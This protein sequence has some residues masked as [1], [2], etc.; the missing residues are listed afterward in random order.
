MANA[1][2]ARED[3]SLTLQEAKV[4]YKPR[5]AD[6]RPLDNRRI[7]TQLKRELR[8]RIELALGANWNQISKNY[9]AHYLIWGNPQ[10][11]TAEIF[12]KDSTVCYGFGAVMR[13]SIR[14]A[15]PQREL[16]EQN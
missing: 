2:R 4:I 1:A 6:S 11:G 10:T 15:L 5:T 12:L 16:F 13:P 9:R 3:R 14:F 8:R 7:R